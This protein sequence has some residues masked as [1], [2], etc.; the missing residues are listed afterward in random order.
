MSAAYEDAIAAL[1]LSAPLDIGQM[2]G[3]PDKAEFSLLLKL[4]APA[5]QSQPATSP[6]SP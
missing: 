1:R 3:C 2:D 5:Q 4:R 6:L